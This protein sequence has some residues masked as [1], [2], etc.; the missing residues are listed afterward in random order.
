MHGLWSMDIAMDRVSAS[1]FLRG[2]EVFSHIFGPDI[3]VALQKNTI[4]LERTLAILGY[5]GSYS[6]AVGW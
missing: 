2:T 3:F 6:Y 1:K 5:K 4:P